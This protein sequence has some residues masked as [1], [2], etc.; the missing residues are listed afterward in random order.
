MRRLLAPLTLALALAIPPVFGNSST[1]TAE[2]I[3]VAPASDFN[4]AESG[5]NFASK[6][7][8]GDDVVYARTEVERYPNPAL[9]VAVGYSSERGAIVTA[10]VYPVG[11]GD[12]IEAVHD[13]VIADVK[14]LY[15]NVKVEGSR[16]KFTSPSKDPGEHFHGLSAQMI[17]TMP[18]NDETH[19]SDLYLVRVGDWWLKFRISYPM[20]SKDAMRKQ[21]VPLIAGITSTVAAK[22]K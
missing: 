21:F 3:D 5:V 6:V 19:C 16:Q 10:Y 13:R 4:H 11:Q 15:R 22:G 8:V 7:A 14:Q 20:K 1:C 18:S 9:G 12:T 17:V 2:T